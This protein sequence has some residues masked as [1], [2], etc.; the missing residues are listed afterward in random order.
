MKKSLLFFAV[1][2]IFIIA[3]HAQDQ[4]KE[5]ITGVT[6]THIYRPKPIPATAERIRTLKVP[7][8]FKVSVFAEN[9]GYPRIMRVT[10]DGKVY[11]TDR[12]TGKLQLLQDTDNDG[13]VDD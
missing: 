6:T 3:G 5:P 7:P 13:K 2:V 12:D 4:N 10:P 9:V 8:G 11:V 1:W